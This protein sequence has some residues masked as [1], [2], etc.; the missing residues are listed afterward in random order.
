MPDTVEKR[1][2]TSRDAILIQKSTSN[3]KS[4]QAERR[5]DSI[6]AQQ[7]LVAEFFNSI[8]PL[9]TFVRAKPSVVD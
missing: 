4:I 3:A 2:L 5:L 7:A 6:I 9:R 8:D 1:F